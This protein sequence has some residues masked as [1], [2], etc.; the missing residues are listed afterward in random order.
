MSRGLIHTGVAPSD[1]VIGYGAMQLAGRGA[2]G[3]PPNRS[4]AVSLLRAAH[5]WGV[6]VIDTAWYYGPYVVQELIA[7][8]LYP[9]PA[10]LLLVTKAG[11][12]RGDRGSWV[13]ALRPCDLRQACETDL[14]LLRLQSL[15][16]V[17]L[18]WS[19]QPSDDAPFA[20][21]VG[22]LVRLQEYGWLE[23]IG[24]SNVTL[25]HLRSASTTT[26]IA[27]V[28]N[29]FSLDNR[30][31]AAVLAYCSSMSIPYLPY[32]PL[33]SGHVLRQP[34]VQLV[35]RELAITPAQLAIAWLRAQSPSVIPIPGT[36]SPIHLRDNIA[37]QRL[38]LPSHALR[39]LQ[40][41]VPPSTLS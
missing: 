35:A 39:T 18:R 17:L 1:P 27:A 40:T 19:P 8:A 34:A 15:P 38:A 30:R 14:R 31:D 16:L 4:D 33:L 24:L 29:A 5:K 7:E 11:N 3:P 28:S 12:S 32:Y 25:R 10:D 13:P 41:Q 21:A 9:Y 23:R 6:T 26:A 36:R 37:A 2:W 22:T 20:D